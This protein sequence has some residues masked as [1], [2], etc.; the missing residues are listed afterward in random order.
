MVIDD[1]TDKNFRHGFFLWMGVA[2]V[3]LIPAILV[4]EDLRRL[5]LK[6][7]EKS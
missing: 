6:D 4:K 7:V 2:L 1:A 5:N 3:A